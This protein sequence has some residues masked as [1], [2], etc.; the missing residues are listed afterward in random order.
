MGKYTIGRKIASVVVSIAT[1]ASMSGAAV[2]VP[3]VASADTISDLQAQIAALSA[4][5]AALIGGGAPAP[6]PMGACTFT[7]NL[8]VGVRGDDVKCLQES[9]IS[10]G[11]LGAGLNTGYFGALTKAAVAKWQA[12]NGVAPA[13]GYF[14]SISRAKFA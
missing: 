11:H 8:T 1:V 2:L 10:A 5:L 9:L 13:V 7:R 3:T 12:A 14:G 6:A 4:Q